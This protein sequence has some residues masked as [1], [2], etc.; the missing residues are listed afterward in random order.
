MFFTENVSQVLM[1]LMNELRKRKAHKQLSG[2]SPHEKA[3]GSCFTEVKL[4]EYTNPIINHFF[5]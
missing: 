4:N 1:L 3:R 5:F 2:L